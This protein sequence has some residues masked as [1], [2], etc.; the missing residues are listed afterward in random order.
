[1]SDLELL[2]QLKHI[3][4]PTVTNVVATYPGHELCLELYHPW[5]A[6]WYT[7][8]RLRCWYPE[9]GPIAGYAV[10]CTYGVT[11]PGYS[12]LSLMDVLE[13][14]D[15][16]GRP[17]IFCF[18]QRFPPELAD[19]VGLAGGNMTSALRA[20]GAVGAVSN[21]PSR[22]IHE[23]RPMKFQ[24]LTRGICAGHGPQ[25]LQAVQVPVR[26][27]GMDVAP[28]DIVHMDENG[29]VKFPAARLEEVVAN[30]KLLLAQEE[31][32]VG[33]LL[34]ARGVDQ[35]RAIMAGHAYVKPSGK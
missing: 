9:L 8:N 6:N 31:E 35:V 25:E 32:R 23:I 27:C 5:Q 2:E 28:G 33:R 19:K 1:M 7:D 18:E 11:D 26:L 17:S 3:D 16:L 30:A 10:T 20:C 4:T 24:Y 13:A 15:K 29:A 12:A 22:D 34:Q 14:A 21:G